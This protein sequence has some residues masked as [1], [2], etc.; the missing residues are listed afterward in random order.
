MWFWRLK[1][2]KKASAESIARALYEDEEVVGLELLP[3]EEILDALK[4]QYPK[5]KLNR[6]NRA[7]EVDIPEEQTAIEPR[8]GTSHFLFTFYG[9]AWKQM[10]HVVEL[11]TRFKL[12]CYD[13]IERKMHTLKKPPRFTGTADEEAINAEW[14]KVMMEERAKIQA[15]ASD[16]QQM[17]KKMKA[18][19][20]SGG[21]ERAREEA[22]RRI[23][24]RKGA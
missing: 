9:D 1:R 14:E 5:I 10:D 22:V 4:R 12:A 16:P 11:M 2:G 7:G 8:W 15:A 13:A 3:V 19:V 23:T 18:F 24:A 6:K 17:L 20:E 21:I